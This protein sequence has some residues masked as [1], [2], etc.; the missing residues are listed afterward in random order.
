MS[1]LR[2]IALTLI[3]LVIPLSLLIPQSSASPEETELIQ[4]LTP[5]IRLELH[6]MSLDYFGQ[7]TRGDTIYEDYLYRIF[8]MD[9]G[10][11]ASGQGRIM[12]IRYGED[13]ITLEQTLILI[14]AEELQTWRIR[15][16]GA[17]YK[18]EYEVDVLP[19]GIPLTIRY[20]NP[21]TGA[22]EERTT[23]IGEQYIAAVEELGADAIAEQVE[24]ERD[25][26]LRNA[27]RRSYSGA[28]LIGREEVEGPD[29]PLEADLVVNQIDDGREVVYAISPEVPG[30]LVYMKVSGPEGEMDVV[31]LVRVPEHSSDDAPKTQRLAAGSIE[32]PIVLSPDRYVEGSID[33]NGAVYFSFTAP[34]TLDYAIEMNGNTDSLALVDYGRDA[35]YWHRMRSSSRDEPRLEYPALSAGSTIYVS[36]ERI[37]DG[38]SPSGSFRL[39][40]RRVSP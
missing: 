17:G 12:E 28:R 3:M 39:G 30:S 16:S 22:L 26:E 34:D 2:R 9:Q 5:A 10:T 36:V 25:E 23:M 40:V 7:F 13:L 37:A 14:S 33:S 21:E 32:D 27:F 4:L 24:M 29:G 35:S 8:R 15:I 18:I 31:R 1:R 6:L 20:L 11:Y 19:S 38:S